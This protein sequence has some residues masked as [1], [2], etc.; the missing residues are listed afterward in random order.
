MEHFTE[1]FGFTYGKNY[2]YLQR[3]LDVTKSNLF[4]AK[5]VIIVEGWSEEILLPELAKKL[6]Y[7]LTEKEVSIINVA[8][9]AY[10]HFAKIFL[11]NDERK[12]NIP[13]SIITDFDNRPDAT[14]VFVENEKSKKK[15]ETFEELRTALKDSSVKLFVAKEWTLEWCLYKSTSLSTQFKES[16]SKVH[17]GTN[18]FKDG[19]FDESKFISK[20]KKEKETTPLDKVQIANKLVDKILEETITFQADDDYL[21]YLVDA[22]KHACNGN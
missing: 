3:F 9:I 7:D 12:L 1:L 18:E 22:I 15:K 10:L 6:G 5:G 4:F 14:G 16:V 17:S 2:L 19:K 13:V 21:K 20:L 8:S 11:R